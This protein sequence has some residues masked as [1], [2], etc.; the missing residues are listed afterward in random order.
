MGIGV[1]PATGA[2]RQSRA[3]VRSFS[4]EPGSSFNATDDLHPSGTYW[5]PTSEPAG[6][7]VSG[8][9]YAQRYAAR[10]FTLTAWLLVQS[11]RLSWAAACAKA[12][13]NSVLGKRAVFRF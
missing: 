2:S 8:T 12:D 10:V 7:L 5:V 3:N 1:P 4:D 9:R 6:F 13:R 11:A